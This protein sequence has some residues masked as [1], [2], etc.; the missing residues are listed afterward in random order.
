MRLFEAINEA[1]DMRSGTKISD[2]FIARA[3]WDIEFICAERRGE[4]SPKFTY[5]D[6]VELSIQP[7]FDSVYLLAAATYLDI[8]NGDTELYDMDSSLRN[9]MLKGALARIDREKKKA[10]KK[11]D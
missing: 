8:V 9:A 10:R 6:D 1:L 7:P 11:N 5:R 4:E 3:I 2:E